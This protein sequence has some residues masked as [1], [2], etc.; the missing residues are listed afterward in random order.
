MG[1]RRAAQRILRPLLAPS[2]YDLCQRSSI[3]SVSASEVGSRILAE[4]GRTWGASDI[5]FDTD[6]SY[7]STAQYAAMA[8]PAWGI[9]KEHARL[10]YG[11]IRAL[12]PER[13]VETGVANGL[14]TALILRAMDRN[15]IG[16]L[17]SVDI[18]GDV[19][20]LVPRELR[21]RWSLCLVGHGAQR[22][23][24]GAIVPPNETLDFF[25]HDSLH[26]YKHQLD[27]Y[28]LAW[29][30]L[31]RGGFLLSDDVDASFAFVDFLGEVGLS[32]FTLVGSTKVFGGV[33]K[34]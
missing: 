25:M 9:E 23:P 19:G 1:G 32:G 21:G 22:Q 11:L 3:H 31:R 26:T 34:L 10:M 14:S 27:E 16:R 20:E 18:K 5:E 24:L 12:R 7:F 28:R 15:A 33:Q 30:A 2:L 13:M 29:P 4:S 8:Y 17:T 6:F